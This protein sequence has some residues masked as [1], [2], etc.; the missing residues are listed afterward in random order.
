MATRRSIK[1]DD[2]VSRGDPRVPATT[3]PEPERREA[4]RTT[5]VRIP[6][7]LHERLKIYCVKNR[8]TLQ[9]LFLDYA[10]DLM[11]REDKGK[12]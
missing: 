8:T 12:G 9:D 2:I 4:T 11:D 1:L 10:V 5:S 6:E 3:T 7:S